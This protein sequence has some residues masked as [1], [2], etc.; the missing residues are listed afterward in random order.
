MWKLNNTLPN[1]SSLKDEVK[2]ETGK[3]FEFNEND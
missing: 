2:R 1:S 3:Y